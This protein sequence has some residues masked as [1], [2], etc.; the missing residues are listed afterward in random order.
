MAAAND[1]RFG[2]SSS[3]FT[4]DASSVFRFVDRIEAGIVH[5]NSG[6]PGGE[7]QL[8]FGGMKATGVGPREQGTHG[9]RVLHRDQDRLR[10]LHRPGPEGR[11]VLSARVAL[12]LAWIAAAAG[13]AEAPLAEPA[14][15]AIRTALVTFA[16][17]NTLPLRNWTLSYDYIS[18]PRGQSPPPGSRPAARPAS[19][20]LGQARGAGRR[21][22]SWPSSTAS[23]TARPWSTAG[24]QRIVSSAAR[25]VTVA[26]P[27]GKTITARSSRRIATCWPRAPTSPRW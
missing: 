25:E 8:P 7:A 17:G 13:A 1:V 3:I 20:W 22:R 18:W 21:T 14:D 10:G 24:P 12:A 6:T 19:S 5:I 26:T 11:A 9:D 2:L 23:S 4:T 15:P 16:D 27:G